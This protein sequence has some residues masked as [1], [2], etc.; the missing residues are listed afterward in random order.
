MQI[1]TSFSKKLNIVLNTRDFYNKTYIIIKIKL[2]I[3]CIWIYTWFRTHSYT[4]FFVI[5]LWPIFLFIHIGNSVMEHFSR[6]LVIGTNLKSTKFTFVYYLTLL[7]FSVLKTSWDYPGLESSQFNMSYQ[8]LHFVGVDDAISFNSCP[9]TACVLSPSV[10]SDLFVFTHRNTS[11]M[12]RLVFCGRLEP[13]MAAL[14][15]LMVI[16][17]F[18]FIHYCIHNI[19]P[20]TAPR[21][22]LYVFF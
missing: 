6:I 1:R 14:N 9:C 10:H 13:K 21:F 20:L 17:H 2:Y 12:H 18:P 22:Y 19:I 16:D 11:F 3:I 8:S 4:V 15:K 7:E 5:Y